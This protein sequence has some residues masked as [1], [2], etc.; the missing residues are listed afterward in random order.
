MSKVIAHTTRIGD[1]RQNNCRFN[2]Q[3]FLLAFHYRLKIPDVFCLTL[4]QIYVCALI[5]RV[6][7]V[8]FFG[9]GSVPP[10]GDDP[11]VADVETCRDTSLH[12]RHVSATSGSFATPPSCGGHGPPQRPPLSSQ[13]AM[14]FC[15]R[16]FMAPF[17]CSSSMVCVALC[18]SWQCPPPVGTFHRTSRQKIVQNIWSST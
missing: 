6:L 5:D 15:K 4:I 8:L 7:A 10:R 1:E 9:G 14:F 18:T 11:D 17:R 13:N 16:R 3:F 2:I 12:P